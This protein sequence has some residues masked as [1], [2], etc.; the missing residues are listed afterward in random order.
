[1]FRLALSG[2]IYFLPFETPTLTLCLLAPLN[3]WCG[4]A[5]L[6]AQ[7]RSKYETWYSER[8]ILQF[9]CVGCWA[10]VTHLRYRVLTSLN[11]DETAVHCCDTALSVLV[12]LV[13]RNVFHVVSALQ[14]IVSKLEPAIWA[15]DTG[16]R[17]PWI[18]RWQLSITW[19]SNIKEVHCKPRLQVSAIIYLVFGR[20]VARLR[21]R[22]AYAPTSNTA[23]HDNQEKIHSWV[24]F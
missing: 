8:V 9:M 11:K 17:I 2:H 4:N 1:M 16:Q 23:S 3:T 20:H 10:G 12:M 24:A 15:R 6:A 18:D 7:V 19:I 14:S 5:C 22:R 21:R 13:S